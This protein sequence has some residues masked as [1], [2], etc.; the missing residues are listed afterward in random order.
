MW[1]PQ[2][3]LGGA[4]WSGNQSLA[5]T[6]QLLSTSAGLANQGDS[7]FDFANI[8][9]LYVST[10]KG[11]NNGTDRINILNTGNITISS[12]GNININASNLTLRATNV[13]QFLNNGQMLLNN[14]DPVLGRTAANETNIL[15]GKGSFQAL[16]GN[17]TV[18]GSS[19]LNFYAGNRVVF[20]S[21]NSQ[22]YLPNGI[23][24]L[25]G[26]NLIAIRSLSTINV[27][28][29]AIR[30]GDIKANSLSSIFVSTG[31]L[32]AG[33]TILDSLGVSG[34]TSLSNTLNMNNQN[35]TNVN[36]I[37]A[38]T[39]NFTT[40]TGNLT[41]N[42]SGNLTGNV[43]GNV[44]G[45][46]TGNVTG[47][48][49]NANLTVS[50]KF[51]ITETA[52]V[53]SAI[54]DYA[55]YGTVNISGK[56]GLG[57]IVNITA[58]VAT[59]LN[60]ALT[61]SQ[62]TLESK[63]NYG[64]F[65]ITPPDPYL[66]YVPRGGLVS[67]IARQGLTPTPPATVTSGLFGNGEID[68]TA[69]SFVNGVFTT[70]GLIKMSAGANSMYAGPISPISGVLGTNNIYGTVAN[71]ITAGTP[72]GV[73]P[74]FPGTNYLYGFAGTSIQNTLY[75]DN[76]LNYGNGV[77]YSNLTI[78]ANNSKDV[79]I[80]NVKSI[81]MQ[82]TPFIDG[83]NTG[84]IQSFSNINSSNL[85]IYRQ[86]Y[87]SSLTV[88]DIIYNK[89]SENFDNLFASTI[90]TSTITGFNNGTQ[91]LSLVNRSSI[92]ISTGANLAQWGSTISLL[93]ANQLNTTS[94]LS[95]IVTA[96]TSAYI[97]APTTTIASGTSVNLNTPIVKVQTHLDT[98]SI[99]TLNF[100][101]TNFLATT[102]TVANTTI[103]NLTVPLINGNPTMS[104]STT[105]LNIQA[106]A[107]SPPPTTVSY[108]YTGADQT[109][110]VPAG[111][112]SINI[113]TMYGAGGGVNT[114][115]T[116][117]TPGKGGS[118]SGTLAVTPGETLTIMVGAGGGN[119]PSATTLYGGGAA[120]NGTGQNG[121]NGGGRTAIRRAG[122][123]VVTAGGGGG[124]AAISAFGDNNA[125]NGGG[126]TGDS[127][128]GTDHSGSAPGATGGGG[129]TQIGVGGGGAGFN[130]PA[131][132]GA[133]GTGSQGGA[134]SY[135]CGGGGGGYFGGGGGGYSISDASSSG[136]GGGGSSYVAN[137]TGTVITVSGGGAIV[138]KPG[139]LIFTY[140]ATP[141]GVINILA[142]IT[143]INSSDAINMTT[144]AINTTTTTLSVSTT[145]TN[146]KSIAS[147]NL[148]TTLA[149]L[150]TSTLTLG[151]N[152]Y[153]NVSTSF[154]N[155]RIRIIT[156][157]TGGGDF[158]DST[159]ILYANT[160][161]VANFTNSD[162]PT[163]GF[164]YACYDAVFTLSGF[165]GTLDA[166]NLTLTGCYVTGA[167][168][169]SGNW[170]ANCRAMAMP[171]VIGP[172]PVLHTK[173]FVTG[174]FFPKTLGAN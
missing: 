72:P 122:V 146:I 25:S 96:G 130:T 133:P 36:T 158:W 22:N 2:P 10:I 15:C 128:Q 147:Y 125:G 98:P 116:Y 67:I 38:T 33:D 174:I 29:G 140:T 99:S 101:A 90:F 71:T 114:S 173:W 47:N 141:P 113:T 111:V 155:R 108:A 93:A 8:S 51:S 45:N 24:D 120:G 168:N 34:T 18:A 137:L 166:Y 9:T 135:Q 75:V 41:G 97:T 53:G 123:D 4:L 59:P 32:K 55:S 136:G 91:T 69:Y 94:G 43:T 44:S 163:G 118:V 83:A 106:S 11:F 62:M 167:V 89:L 124:G 102:V 80:S 5:T 131:E 152:L 144:N 150:N 161:G 21:Y 28:T 81:Y 104:I 151:G 171:G 132:F 66:G 42:V 95:T 170:F 110:T 162:S 1:S 100:Q 23:V 107:T 109:F 139:S 121:T 103:A 46:L 26:N 64:V 82:N 87:I 84:T 160:T 63:G 117:S 65:V 143:N 7:N 39:G 50:G 76:I 164:E 172:P 58:D 129:G 115:G 149:N 13:G 57:G 153:T 142:G 154:T 37:G 145:T 31:L 126:T 86:G 14:T 77:T 134:P 165:D 138:T 157:D 68:L 79:L 74:T 6:R 17:L 16:A 60:P 148:S 27:S 3:A 119:T 78:G 156:V 70:P 88:D 19:N 12:F 159:N 20:E 169:G 40:L 48:I 105:G 52:D 92:N 112:Y 35:I 56:G 61:V 54:A 73:I 49:S 127:G 30:A 85:N